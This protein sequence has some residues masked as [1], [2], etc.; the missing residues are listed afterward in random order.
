MRTLNQIQIVIRRAGRPPNK[1][2]QRGLGLGAG[3][4]PGRGRRRQRRPA[5][6]RQRLKVHN[7]N[8]MQ[9]D[10][11]EEHALLTQIVDY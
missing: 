4:G 8:I 5:A 6:T 2:P 11:E 1:F 10:R 7:D 9:E 3:V